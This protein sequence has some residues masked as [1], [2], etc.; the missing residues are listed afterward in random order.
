MNELRTGTENDPR[1]AAVVARDPGAKFYYSVRT[2][3]VYCRPCCAARLARPENVQFHGSCEEAERAG[4]RPCQRCRPDQASGAEPHAEKITAACRLIESSDT[5]PSLESL[6]QHV[7]LSAYHFHRVFKAATGLTPRGYAAAHRAKQVRKALNKSETVTGAIYDAGYNSNSRF[8]ETSN[9]VLGMTPSS[10]RAGGEQTD[11][12]FAVGECSL[13]S[14]LVAQSARWIC[15][16]LLGDSPDGLVCQLQ[17]Q[18]PKANIIGGDAGFEELV[19]KVVG[20]V[21]APAAGL[22]LPLDGTAPAF[23]DCFP[24]SVSGRRCDAFRPALQRVI[25]MLQSSSA[26][27][28]RFAPLHTHVAPMRWRW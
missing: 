27:R 5:P 11:I 20:F 17:D 26:L 22:D 6:A 28:I 2:T 4:F 3:G 8:Y 7:R 13:G 25:P 16:V 18:F 21:E 14:I 19:A 9:Q 23:A 10:Y 12:R 24:S 15:A 1:W